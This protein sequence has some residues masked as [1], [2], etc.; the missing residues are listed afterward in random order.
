MPFSKES[1]FEHL[2]ESQ[3]TGRLAHAYLLTGPPGS[4]K[5]WLASHLAALLLKCSPENALAHPDAHTV[6]PESK[7]RRIVIDQ[8]RELE[9]SIQRRPLLAS[10][11]VAIIH[12]ADRLQPQ[13][14]NAFLKTLEEPPPGSLI[15]LLSTRPKAIVETAR[16]RC[17]EI[18]LLEAM[19]R[20][21]AAEEMAIREALKECLVDH[22]IPG[23]AEAFRFTRALQGILLSLRE[24]I[25]SEYESILRKETTRYGQA[26]DDSSW[27][28]ERTAQ[29]KALVEAGAVGER[30]RILQ[31]VFDAI[32][33]ALRAQHGMPA[34]NPVVDALARKIPTRDLLR[35]IDVLESL[36]YR[37][38]RGVQESLA[39]ES[40]FLEM[41]NASRVE[42]ERLN[43]KEY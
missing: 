39:L 22:A 43:A 6:Q 35:R 24:K 3:R 25:A 13:A 27:L 42:P 5:S 29:I 40:G 20:L 12:D 17:I 31:I 19:K 33:A 23:V 16:S 4:G 26:L 14:V 36:R 15:L 7:S 32:G 10:S 30:E 9:H 21:P 2:S 37:L 34:E 11:K 1:A 28:E 41:I 8:I 38:A 18:P